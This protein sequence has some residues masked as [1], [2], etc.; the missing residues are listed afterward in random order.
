MHTHTTHKLVHH[1][2]GDTSSSHSGTFV[3]SD[4]VD[5]IPTCATTMPCF[6]LL[7]TLLVTRT[8]S[9]VL[10]CPPTHSSNLAHR[11]RRHCLA[12]DPFTPTPRGHQHYRCNNRAISHLDTASSTHLRMR[13]ISS[14]LHTQWGPSTSDLRRES[15]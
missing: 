13:L 4:T 7:H 15:D 2:C 1:L 5:S 8:H 10:L 12:R 6:V 14:R 11:T 9:P 3:C